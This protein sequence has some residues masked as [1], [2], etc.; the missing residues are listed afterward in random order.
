M[1][2]GGLKP[3]TLKRFER[4]SP[5]WNQSRLG[6]GDKPDGT[7]EYGS[8]VVAVPGRRARTPH[9]DIQ[10]DAIRTELDPVSRTVLVC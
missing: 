4:L 9:T 6:L 3:N 10:L 7:A 5:A 8:R 1:D 2:A